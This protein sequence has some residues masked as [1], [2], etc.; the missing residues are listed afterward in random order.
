M[1][2]LWPLLVSSYHTWAEDYLEHILVPL[3]NY[4]SRGTAVFLA[5]QNPN[6]LQQVRAREPQDP[7]IISYGTGIVHMHWWSTECNGLA[8]FALAAQPLPCLQGQPRALAT[9]SSAH[10]LGRERLANLAGG[11]LIVQPWC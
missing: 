1:W 4:I 5:G 11:H 9:M 6:Y 7:A 10:S 8:Q 2:D 3:E